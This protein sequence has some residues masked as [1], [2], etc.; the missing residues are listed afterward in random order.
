MWDLSH[1]FTWEV[2]LFGIK[3][4][5][6]WRFVTDNLLHLL[7]SL[8]PSP[9]PSFISH[10]RYV[11]EGESFFLCQDFFLEQSLCGIGSAG[12]LLLVVIT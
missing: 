12:L 8:S 4:T 9:R 2:H 1:Y 11:R 10:G 5:G 3:R 6:I 7:L